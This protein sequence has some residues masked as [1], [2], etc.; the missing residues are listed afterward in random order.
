MRPPSTAPAGAIIK[1]I[2][3]ADPDAAVNALPRADEIL[4]GP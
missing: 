3:S 4:V 1:A 2:S